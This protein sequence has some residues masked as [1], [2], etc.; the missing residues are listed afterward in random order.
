MLTRGSGCAPHH[1][2]NLFGTGVSSLKLKLQREIWRHISSMEE[3]ALL[4]RCVKNDEKILK[5]RSRRVYYAA[6]S[7]VN[8]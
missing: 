8:R 5:V 2:G 6:L 7:A 4:Q 3:P 1:H